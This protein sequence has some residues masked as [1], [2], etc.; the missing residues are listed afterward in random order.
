MDSHHTK[1]GQKTTIPCPKRQKAF[2]NYL[3]KLR[4]VVEDTIS[5]MKKFTVIHGI[6]RH[7]SMNIARSSLLLDLVVHVIGILTNFHLRKSPI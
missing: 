3:F 1:G 4:V 7:Y 5:C 2:N 6:Y